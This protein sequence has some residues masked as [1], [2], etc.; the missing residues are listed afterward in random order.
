MLTR[1]RNNQSQY[2]RLSLNRGLTNWGVN[3]RRWMEPA[4]NVKQVET[5]VISA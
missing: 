1:D 4:L 5:I 2:P 3:P